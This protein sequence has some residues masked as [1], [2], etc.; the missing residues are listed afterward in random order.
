MKVIE[1]LPEECQKE[2][3]VL[4]RFGTRKYAEW[5]I[6]IWTTLDIDYTVD[7]ANKMRV[8][9]IFVLTQEEAKDKFKLDNYVQRND[10]NGSDKVLLA[11]D[12]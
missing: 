12:Q 11:K 10:T 6:D 5:W 9:R 7:M 4:V 8:K 3:N 1:F 2:N